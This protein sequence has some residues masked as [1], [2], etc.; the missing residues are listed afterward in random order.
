MHE[1]LSLLLTLLQ[2]RS[3]LTRVTHLEIRDGGVS[4]DLA[5][6]AAPRSLAQ[7]DL[8]E[9]KRTEARE[10]FEARIR[11]GASGRI[12]RGGT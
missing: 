10:A 8:E 3:L 9:A 4:I 7:A 12:E 5:P 11:N 2:E 6:T 1:Q